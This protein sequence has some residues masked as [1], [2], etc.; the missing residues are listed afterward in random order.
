VRPVF[1][2]LH[3]ND[4]PE[5]CGYCDL[6]DEQ[7]YFGAKRGAIIFGDDFM[8]LRTMSDRDKRVSHKSKARMECRRPRIIALAEQVNAFEQTL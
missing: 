5:F 1:L 7:V 3:V 8:H 4:P 6:T 2:R